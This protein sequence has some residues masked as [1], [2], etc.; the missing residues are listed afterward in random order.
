MFLQGHDAELSGLQVEAPGSSFSATPLGDVISQ[1]LAA[2]AGGRRLPLLFPRALNIHHRAHQTCL[3]F[4][5]VQ[6]LFPEFREQK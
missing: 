5:W 1:Q 6:Q 2:R 4:I 3:G